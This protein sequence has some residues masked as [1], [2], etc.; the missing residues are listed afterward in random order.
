[1]ASGHAHSPASRLLRM[2]Q[3]AKA[4]PDSTHPIQLFAASPERIA[5]RSC[6][7]RLAGELC[8]PDDVGASGQMH[9]PASRFLRMSLVTKA[10]PDSTHPIQ[11]SLLHLNESLFG[12]VGAGLLANCAGQATLQRLDKCIRQQAGSYG[13]HW[14]QRPHRTALTRSS[15]SL[16]HLN[17]SLFGAVGAG[18]LANTAGQTTLQ[19]LDKCIRQQ[20]GSYRFYGAPGP[21]RTALTPSSVENEV[22]FA[23]RRKSLM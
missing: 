18:L 5:I 16:L 8:G 12:A 23:V 7:S 22:S 10:S 15:F 2:S 13:C 20:A 1:M 4:S 14:S 21:H 17:E 19:R 9:S 6:R 11:L 3:V